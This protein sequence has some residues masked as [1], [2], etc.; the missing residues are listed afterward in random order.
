MEVLKSFRFLTPP[1][2]I[3]FDG[4]HNFRA[5]SPE[6]HISVNNYLIS[7]IFLHFKLIVPYH[8]M[9][10][11]ERPKVTFV[12]FHLASPPEMSIIVGYAS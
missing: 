8:Y 3:S 4:L 9:K 10:K 7:L 5:L 6:L 2:I 1:P 12:I 11:Y